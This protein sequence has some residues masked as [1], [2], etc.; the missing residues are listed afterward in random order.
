ML[1]SLHHCTSIH[2]LHHKQLHG[3]TLH[4]SHCILSGI[5][6]NCMLA[7]TLHTWCTSTSHTMVTL[8]AIVFTAHSAAHCKL[9][10]AWNCAKQLASACTACPLMACQFPH[11]TI[12]T[13]LGFQMHAPAHPF[14][15]QF[16]AYS[17]TIQHHSSPAALT[18]TSASK[19][20]WLVSSCLFLDVLHTFAINMARNALPWQTV[21]AC[22]C[23]LHNLNRNT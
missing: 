21:K 5:C 11:Q 1:I 16:K 9:C 7:S 12:A 6:C 8:L 23:E 20:A 10:T 2:I 18:C 22:S 14:Q 13:I 19:L 4:P 17:T 15:L 3:I